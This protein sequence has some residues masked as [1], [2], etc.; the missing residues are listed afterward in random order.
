MNN[1]YDDNIVVLCSTS[2]CWIRE[3]FCFLFEEG[4]NSNDDV[5]M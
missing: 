3:N 5:V 1:S 2:S 4:N